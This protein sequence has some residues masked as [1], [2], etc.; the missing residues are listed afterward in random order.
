[1]EENKIVEA[2]P[3]E[4][5]IFESQ[6][7]NISKNNTQQ[8]YKNFFENGTIYLRSFNGVAVFKSIRRAIRRGH[9]SMYGDIYPRRPFNN[10][11]RNKKGDITY[12]RRQVY[13]QLKTYE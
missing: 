13:K 6:I 5:E 3:V 7:E 8:M 10:R 11:K 1:M 4:E 12:Q 2:T 9:C